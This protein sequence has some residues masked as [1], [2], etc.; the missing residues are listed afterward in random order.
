ME[1]FTVLESIRHRV[2]TIELWSNGIT[3]IKMD[4][5]AEML[6]E[7]SLSQYNELKKR[8][9]GK[10]KYKL[11]VEPGRYTTISAEAREF[12]TQKENNAMTAA[13]AV[14]IKSLAHRLVINFVINFTQKQTMKMRMFES[15][16]KA[17]EWLLTFND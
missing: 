13:S 17:I 15:K 3:Y 9:D 6:L 4:D 5:N 14:V 8:Y 12:S 16:D 7:D 1:P 10:T 11:L 2:S